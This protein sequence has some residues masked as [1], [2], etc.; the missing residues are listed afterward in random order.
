M[1]FYKYVREAWKKPKENMPELWKQ[2]LKKW[3]K[4]PTTVRVKRPT[5]IDRARSLG[6]K[7]KPGFIVVRH[8]ISRGGRMRPKIRAG[9]RPKHN[10]R[11]LIL[12]KSY[13]QIAEERANRKYPN[14]EVMNSYWV[15]EDGKHYWYEIILVDRAH[16]A[17]ITDK[18]KGWITM[19]QHKGR[20][21]RGLTSAGRKS[22]GL[23]HKGIGSEKTRPSLRANKRQ[24]N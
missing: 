20:A 6:Y 9:R 24:G 18:D 7:A 5:R 22:R 11:K 23:R 4:G 19:P 15:A 13:Q 12:S 2:R 10:R 21:G 14:C 17:V 8:R 16:P 3:R 1:G